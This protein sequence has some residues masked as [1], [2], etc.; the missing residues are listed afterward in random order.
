ML[1]TGTVV[2]ASDAS[3]AM[4]SV[5][6]VMFLICSAMGSSN[7]SALTV[8]CVPSE[9]SSCRYRRI[10]RPRLLLAVSAAMALP[11]ALAPE[12][13]GEHVRAVG[14]SATTTEGTTP[15]NVLDPCPQLVADRWVVPPRRFDV[16]LLVGTSVADGPPVVQPVRQDAADLAL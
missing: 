16:L 13:L 15:A 14:A 10:S 2:P 9:Q 8:T 12:A 4:T 5:L 1:L 11:A 6:N 7:A 3:L